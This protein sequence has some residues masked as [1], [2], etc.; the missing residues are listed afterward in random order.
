MDVLEAI[1]SFWGSM[2]LTWLVPGYL[3]RLEQTPNEE[4]TTQVQ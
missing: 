1:I 2:I 4:H 3:G